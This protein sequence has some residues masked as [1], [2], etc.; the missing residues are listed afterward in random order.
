MSNAVAPNL[1]RQPLIQ[2]I[3]ESVTEPST[4]PEL[5]TPPQ[6]SGHHFQAIWCESW[7]VCGNVRIRKDLS[8]C[9]SVDT[10]ITSQDII[11]GL[12]KAG[13]D[14]D[15]ITAIQRRASNNS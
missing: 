3:G 5:F 15:S 12:D 1:V 10:V 11:V 4:T 6:N 14:I 8:V 9:F 13:I 7:N 2:V